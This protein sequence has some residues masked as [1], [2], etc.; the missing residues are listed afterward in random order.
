MNGVELSNDLEGMVNGYLQ[1]LADALGRLPG[2]RRDQLVGEIREHI[3]Q[4]RGEYPTRDRSDM[5]A[6]LNRVGLP[7]DIAAV[8]LEGMEL[9]EDE[10]PIQVIV[11]DGT[12][13]GRSKRT[14]MLVTA[15]AVLLVG[16]LSL[17][18]LTH[19][20]SRGVFTIRQAGVVFPRPVVP[21]LPDLQVRPTVRVTVPD[22]VGMRVSQARTV[23]S[24]VDLPVRFAVTG[25]LA[26]SVAG[27]VTFQSP[28][29]GTVVGEG[30]VITLSIATGSP[31]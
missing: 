12:P 5:E 21:R 17:V 28:P 22:F 10:A 19:G 27:T 18:A 20:S 6:L 23:A 24:A 2:H 9:E 1:E 13:H 30:A 29:A 4:L 16:V 31:S 15:A 3:S 11:P 8:A 14:V 26:N 25:P 7:E